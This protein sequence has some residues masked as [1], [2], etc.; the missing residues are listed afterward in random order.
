MGGH[1]PVCPDG[2]YGPLQY[3]ILLTRSAQHSL[4]INTSRKSHS[5]FNTNELNDCLLRI[6]SDQKLS[7]SAQ[8]LLS[9]IAQSRMVAGSAAPSLFLTVLSQF[10]F[11]RHYF[12]VTQ[13]TT[14]R[15]QEN[16]ALNALHTFC[17]WFIHLVGVPTTQQNCLHET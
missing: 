2:S 7:P 12:H 5:L 15:T 14:K 9:N 13:E 3:I 10:I 16:I 4:F 1:C 11:I 6:V 8:S 17:I